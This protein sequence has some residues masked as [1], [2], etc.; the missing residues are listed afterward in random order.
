MLTVVEAVVIDVA[1]SVEG[2]IIIVVKT[3]VTGV[4]S[5]SAVVVVFNSSFYRWRSCKSIISSC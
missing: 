2:I 5:I 1:D 3:A 4:V